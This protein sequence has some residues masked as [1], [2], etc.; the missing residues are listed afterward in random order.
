MSA[1]ICKRCHR[2][3]VVNAAGYCGGCSGVLRGQE[4]RRPVQDEAASAVLTPSLAQPSAPAPSLEEKSLAPERHE[5]GPAPQ[6][7]FPPVLG[8]EEVTDI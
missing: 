8:E 2:L 1:T 5:D 4:R 7:F 3:K 6:A